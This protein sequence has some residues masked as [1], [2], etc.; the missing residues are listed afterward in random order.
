MCSE[1]ELYAFLAFESDGQCIKKCRNEDG[2]FVGTST[3][4]LTDESEEEDDTD[5]VNNARKKKKIRTDMTKIPLVF[6]DDC[7]VS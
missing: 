2:E 1:G 3:P 6:R 5:G 7:C 4:A